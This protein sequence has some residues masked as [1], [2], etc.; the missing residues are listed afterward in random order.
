MSSAHSGSSLPYAAAPSDARCVGCFGGGG[1]RCPPMERTASASVP[2]TKLGGGASGTGSPPR[3][4]SMSVEGDSERR[5]DGG[6]DVELSS[7]CTTSSTARRAVE[8]LTST[9]SGVSRSSWVALCTRTTT[10][11]WPVSR[12]TTRSPGAGQ[13]AP[14]SPLNLAC[15]AAPRGGAARGLQ[16][17]LRCGTTCEGVEQRSM[18]TVALAFLCA[19][20]LWLSHDMQA[21]RHHVQRHHN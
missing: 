4:A 12:S 14:A 15:S 8:P 11:T 5:D 20:K 9:S 19:P 17:R 7:A 3:S 21:F 1:G 18:L 2:T 10:A 6:G 13:A 16:V